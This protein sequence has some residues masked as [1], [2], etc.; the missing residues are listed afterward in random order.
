MSS[1]AAA[2]PQSAPERIAR[3]LTD[4]TAAGQRREVDVFGDFTDLAALAVRNSIRDEGWQDRED[5]YLRVAKTYTREE[6]GRFA[7]AMGVLAVALCEEPADVLGQVYMTGMRSRKGGF[8]NGALG[9]FFTPPSVA[10]LMAEMTS[11]AEQLDPDDPDDFQTLHEPASGSGTMILATA[12]VMRA[13]GVDP[14][15][16][17]HVHAV[18]LDRRVMRMCYLQLALA[19]IPALVEQGNSITGELFAVWPTPAHVAGGWDR[20]LQ[21]LR[22]RDTGT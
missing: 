11:V 1:R 15:D 22:S 17:L 13:R 2:R 14:S 5:E 8:G 7:E 9:Q 12:A 3:L 21:D 16:K 20:R 10:R 18:D 19:G 4:N 6:L